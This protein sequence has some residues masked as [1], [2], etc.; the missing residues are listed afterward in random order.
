[1]CNPFWYW[2]K[3]LAVILPQYLAVLTSN[4]EKIPLQAS[5]M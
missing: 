5:E 3:L 4:G 2:N 1:M